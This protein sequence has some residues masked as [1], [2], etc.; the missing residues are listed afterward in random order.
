[1]I[2]H[3]VLLKPLDGLPSA[4]RQAVLNAIKAAVAASPSVRGARIGRRLR[5]GLPGYEQAMGEDYEY[6]LLLEFDDVDGL[7]EYLT[8]P[9]HGMVGQY[10]TSAASAALAYDYDVRPLDD[11]QRLV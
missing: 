6:A 10:F 4:G 7:K 5:H 9:E 8:G 11:A 3:L 1:M 2:V